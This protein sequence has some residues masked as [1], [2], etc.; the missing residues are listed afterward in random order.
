MAV[1]IGIMIQ[2]KEDGILSPS[3]LFFFIVAGQIII[4]G[5]SNLQQ[6]H[7]SKNSITTSDCRSPSSSRNK[8]TNVRCGVLCD[9][10]KHVHVI[11]HLLSVQFE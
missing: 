6:F 1:M 7:S 3:S 8:G 9:N 5:N 2:V 4:T 11:S 10:S